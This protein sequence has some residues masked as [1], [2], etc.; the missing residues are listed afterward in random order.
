M[1]TTRR[2]SPDIILIGLRTSGKSTLGR[3]LAGKLRRRFVDLDEEVAVMSRLHTAGE[4]IRQLGLDAFRD[5]ETRALTRLLEV[6][7]RRRPFVLALG[8]GTPTAP[9]AA[10]LLRA[11]R[12]EERVT[13]LYLRANVA[14]LKTRLKAEIGSG[15]ADR[16]SV[17]GADPVKE[18]GELFKTRD[19]LY[20]ELANVVIDAE[21][22]PGRV[23]QAMVREARA[24]R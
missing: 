3:T 17:T 5:A 7:T 18:V 20:R 13:I 4:V 9:G 24:A 12:D 16:P 8:G 11:A 21:Q 23:V 10:E 15:A 14:T 6:G 19:P 2:S 1:A 22:T